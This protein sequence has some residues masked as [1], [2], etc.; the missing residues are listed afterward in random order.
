MVIGMFIVIYFKTIGF[1]SGY[2]LNC[3]FYNDSNTW[4][5]LFQAST[6]QSVL[7]LEM[8]NRIGWCAFSIIQ[9]LG[10][11]AVMC[12]VAWQVFVI[13]IPVTAVCIWYQVCDPFSLI[14]DRT[15]KSEIHSSFKIYT[16]YNTISQV[17][18]INKESHISNATKLKL[19]HWNWML[20]TMWS[21]YLNF[22]FNI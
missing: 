12:Q 14:Y 9:I 4:K 15:E 3:S 20:K 10:T 5:L 2:S 18:H 19:R 13:F 21:I 7:D 11:I 8:A 16:R 6:D 1:L 17:Y 22:K